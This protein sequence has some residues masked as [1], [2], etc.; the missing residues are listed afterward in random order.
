MARKILFE[1]S[2]KDRDIFRIVE[3]NERLLLTINSV[4]GFAMVEPTKQ[5]VQDLITHL[6]KLID[7]E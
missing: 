7:D 2:D 5:N 1:F 4:N 6:K 3:N